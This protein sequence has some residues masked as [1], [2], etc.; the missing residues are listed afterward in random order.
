MNVLSRGAARPSKTLKTKCRFL[1]WVLK[2]AK[3]GQDRSRR[4]DWATATLL[5]L[6]VSSWITRTHTKTH[7]QSN[8]AV[9]KSLKMGHPGNVR[10]TQLM[11]MRLFAA[12]R[13]SERSYGWFWLLL[14]PWG[15]GA[16]SSVWVF[17]QTSRSAVIIKTA[18]PWFAFPQIGFLLTATYCAGKH[19]KQGSSPSLDTHSQ[20][21]WESSINLVLWREESPEITLTGTGRM[22]RT[23]THD[24]RCWT[25]RILCCPLADKIFPERP[26]GIKSCLWFKEPPPNEI[27]AP[28]QTQKH[29]KLSYETYIYKL[30]TIC[31]LYIKRHPKD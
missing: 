22:C 4:H 30:C 3:G 2:P 16:F 28:S 23:H 20:A 5:H 9:K 10:G 27:W 31:T 13:Y 19:T 12:S 26:P 21:T 18:F 1:K 7:K 24:V 11:P 8:S 17:S 6:R 14:S 29:K 15:F 25:E